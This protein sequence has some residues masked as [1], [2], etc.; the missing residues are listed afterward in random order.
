MVIICDIMKLKLAGVPKTKVQKRRK[1]K[2][3]PLL[4]QVNK[5]QQ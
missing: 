5:V 4:G 3:L 1:K 2:D